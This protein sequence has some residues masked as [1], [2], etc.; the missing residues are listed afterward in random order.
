[1]QC[2][3]VILQVLKEQSVS[4]FMIK[5]SKKLHWTWSP[6]SPSKCWYGFARL[7]VITSQKTQFL[8]VF[9][10]KCF[11]MSASLI[12]REYYKKEFYFMVII[13]LRSIS[14][15]RHIMSSIAHSTIF[16]LNNLTSVS[17]PLQGRLS[18]ISTLY[19]ILQYCFWCQI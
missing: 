16:L 13:H 8:N 10:H 6:C 15:H 18:A 14:I 5:G 12:H 4:I 2:S 11:K 1:M 9:R 19:A 7:Q 17:F 3:L